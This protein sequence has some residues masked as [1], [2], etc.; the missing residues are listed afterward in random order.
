MAELRQLP[1]RRVLAD[2]LRIWRDGGTLSAACVGQRSVA[3]WR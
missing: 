1:G 2:G 3:W